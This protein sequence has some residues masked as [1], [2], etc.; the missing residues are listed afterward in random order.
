MKKLLV[1]ILVLGM[2]SFAN[3]SITLSVNGV[4]APDSIALTPSEY[5]TLDIMIGDVD[6]AGGTFDI[7]LSNPQGSLDSSGV[8]FETMPLTRV[9][10]YGAWITGDVLW[11]G[12]WQK[13]IEQPQ[14]VMVA[15][16]NL[17]NN[18]VGPY[19]LMDGLIFHC[20]EATDLI[21]DLVAFE[22]LDI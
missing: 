8:T 4:V 22:G 2:A 12:P 3:A 13:V 16:L 5:V 20:D 10:Y 19:T 21:I 14:R 7:L 11:E 6:L 1:L 17:N 18:T 15:G 9:W